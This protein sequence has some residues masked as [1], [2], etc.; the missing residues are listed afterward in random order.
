MTHSWRSHEEFMTTHPAWD[1][2]VMPMTSWAFMLFAFALG[3]ADCA[4][5][6]HAHRVQFANHGAPPPT[7]TQALY[8]L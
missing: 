6:V 7:L 4:C 8:A 5:T 3:S 1:V 2:A